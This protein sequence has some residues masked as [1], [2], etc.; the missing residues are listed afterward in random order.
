[1]SAILITALCIRESESQ[2]LAFLTSFHLRGA[3]ITCV[4]APAC[5]NAMMAVRVRAR[6]KDV[7]QVEV[8]PK[9]RR[10]RQKDRAG[11]REC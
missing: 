5:A 9:E 6:A 7:E 1:M 8:P 4:C 3:M 2:I 10:G 11:K